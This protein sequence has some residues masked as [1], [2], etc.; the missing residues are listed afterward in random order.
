MTDINDIA[1]EINTHMT[2]FRDH[3]NPVAQLNQL[4]EQIRLAQESDWRTQSLTNPSSLKRWEGQEVWSYA[5]GAREAE[6]QHPVGTTTELRKVSK[7]ESS[8]VSLYLNI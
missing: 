3:D 6:R 4:R 2:S 5:W 7:F 8:S 1:K